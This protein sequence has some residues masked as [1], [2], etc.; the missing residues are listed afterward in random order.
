MTSNGEFTAGNPIFSFAAAALF[1]VALLL[2]VIGGSARE[3]AGLFSGPALICI[4]LWVVS[5][6]RQ[7]NGWE[8]VREFTAHRGYPNPSRI[9]GWVVAFAAMAFG[10]LRLTETLG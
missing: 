9:V 1:P 10:V 8:S 5:I 6:L 3:Y 2:W 4:G 7:P